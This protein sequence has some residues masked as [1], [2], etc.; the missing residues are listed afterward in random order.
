MKEDDPWYW[1][2]LNAIKDQVKRRAWSRGFSR[3]STIE[4]TWREGA[5]RNIHERN[6]YRLVDILTLLLAARGL[7][8]RS[9]GACG[10]Y[11]T[12]ESRA[13]P[14]VLREN[15]FLPCPTVRAVVSFASVITSHDAWTWSAPR[16]ERTE[17]APRIIAA[18]VYCV[19]GEYRSRADR[20]GLNLESTLD[21]TVNFQLTF[22]HTFFPRAT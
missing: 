11:F 7:C 3:T 19:A 5:E 6:F 20:L 16:I 10:R 17:A 12:T 8:E 21:G 9:I 14:I 22:R 18:R 15:D 13:T 4:D 1:N 2:T